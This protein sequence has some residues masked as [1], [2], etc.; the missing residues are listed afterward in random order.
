MTEILIL[1]NKTGEI[2]KLSNNQKFR[3]LVL[4]KLNF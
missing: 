2:L 3:L 1:I 4:Q